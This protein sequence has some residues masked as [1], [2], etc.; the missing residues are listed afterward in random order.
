[1]STDT[2]VHKGLEGVVVDTTAVSLVDGA[3][4]ALSY[5]GHDIAGLVER[6]FAEVAALVATGEFDRGFGKRLAEHAPLSP[7]E[8]D[9]V[10]ALPA[11]THPMHV[12]QGVTPLLDPSDGFAD[13]GDAAQGF[14]VAAKLPT[15]I[16]THLQRRRLPTPTADDPIALFLTQIEAPALE[17]VHRGF[18]VA[19]ILQ[20]EH[21]FNAGTFT[22]RVVA[23]TLAPVENAVSAA[24]GALHGRLHGGADQAALETADRVGTPGNAAAFV[25]RCLEH[26]ERVMGMG[27]REYRVVDPR[28]RLLKD[29]ARQLAEGTEHEVT[30]RTLEAIEARFSERMAERGKPLYAN[31]EFYKGLVFR[32]LGVP[33]RFFTALFGMARVYGYLAHF[34]E[35]REDNRLVRP[36]A[37]YVGR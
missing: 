9:L 25:D 2:R 34:A 35:S 13:R 3:R 32:A 17:P 4:G 6:P 8:E 14:A 30:F 31:V 27:H 21:G 37:K 15:L 18:E 1:M 11:S 24:L 23:S 16:A 22:A 5:R 12:L 19:Q 10:L 29:L 33:P 20:L 7:R 28:A 36:Q 26:G